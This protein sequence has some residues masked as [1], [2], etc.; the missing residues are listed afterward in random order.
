MATKLWHSL[1]FIL[2]ITYLQKS[3]CKKKG[4]KNRRISSKVENY[5][6]N[7]YK[8]LGEMYDHDIGDIQSNDD[9]SIHGENKPR[10]GT[11]SKRSI[12]SARNSLWDL[13]VPYVIDE[14]G[15]NPED[16]EAIETAMATWKIDTCLDFERIRNIEER[17][18][19]K[20]Y[21]LFGFY[22]NPEILKD[23]KFYYGRDV[24][25]KAYKTF[26]GTG[27]TALNQAANIAKML[28]IFDEYHRP[29]AD[30]YMLYLRQNAKPIRLGFLAPIS[31]SMAVDFGIPFDFGSLVMA[32]VYFHSDYT[33]DPVLPAMLPRNGLYQQTMGSTIFSGQPS[34]YDKKLVNIAYCFHRKRHPSYINDRGLIGSDPTALSAIDCSNGGYAHP[35]NLTKCICPRGF[36]GTTCDMISTGSP[37]TCGGITLTTPG[38]IESPGY[39]IG[40]SGLGY[41]KW[42]TC[43]WM[44]Q[45]PA[46]KRVQ[47]QF[48]DSFDLFCSHYVEA[49]LSC[50]DWVE[51]KYE[52]DLAKTGIRFCCR[53][54]PQVILMSETN[55]M[56]VLFQSN[57]VE[58]L[59]G[60]RAKYTFETGAQW[61]EWSQWTPCSKS[62]GGCGRRSRKRACLHHQKYPR[63]EGSSFD[64]ETCNVF[65]CN[66]DVSAKCNGCSL[67]D[68][69]K[70]QECHRNCEISGTCCPGYFKQGIMCL[71]ES[72]RS[73]VA[74]ADWWKPRMHF[75]QLYT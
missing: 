24:N 71:P 62:C 7:I 33:A 37:D 16:I 12:S 44:I 75:N 48:I 50:V 53:Q 45:A 20:N 2:M 29:D 25:E 21:V 56:M 17:P 39:F 38:I 1:I 6:L 61:A 26:A 4:N 36:I 43:T 15:L 68:A 22:R 18:D 46:D 13:P 51:V 64:T 65:A 49:A 70:K 63:C 5:G 52:K 66:I 73:F 9:N 28:G 42:Q 57:G 19:I 40:K 72:R 34:F 31:N 55:R 74:G 11:R 23:R 35:L 67:P 8:V 41:K 32:P 54:T 69:E 58:G 27:F 47:I 10:E 14:D 30:K 60:F 59:Q 3:M